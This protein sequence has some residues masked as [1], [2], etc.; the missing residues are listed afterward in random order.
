MP[1]RHPS[2]GALRQ[3]V[4]GELAADDNIAVV[5][6]LLDGCPRCAGRTSR[7]WTE[8][9]ALRGAPPAG[10]R[11]PAWGAVAQ[12][13]EACR[14]AIEAERREAAASFEKLA[15]QPPA[16]RLLLLQNTRRYAS[17]AACLRLVEAAFD[18]GFDQPHQAVATA[19]LALDAVRALDASYG[20]ELLADLQARAWG[21]LG[22]AR[23]IVS[24]L[25]G[26]E[27]ALSRARELLEEGTGDPIEAAR[28]ASFLASQRTAQRRLDEALELCRRAVAGYRRAGED[29][30]AAQTLVDEGVALGYLG[31]YDEAVRKLEEAVARIDPRERPRNLLAARHNQILFLEE[32]G[33]TEEALERVPEAR[34]LARLHGRRI[35]QLRVRWLEAKLLAAV[36]RHEEAASGLGEVADAFLEEAMPYAAAIAALERAALLFR[37]GRTDEIG[38]IAGEALNVFRSLGIEREALAALTLLRRAAERRELTLAALESTLATVRRAT[39]RKGRG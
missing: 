3:F 28:L 30:L 6:H 26:A 16:R 39:P 11:E 22:N 36:G 19:V 9:I 15:D 12:R 21:V 23:R 8:L 32:A 1:D 37:L 24:D 34:E 29:Q 7:S 4:Q 20:A 31:R 17:P 25:T 27:Q 18:L 13:V 38:A 5:R 2:G 14:A 10:E 33:R 35:D